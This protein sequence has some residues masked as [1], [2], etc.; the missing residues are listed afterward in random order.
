MLIS[1]LYSNIPA[2]QVVMNQASV[3][4]L[5]SSTHP[6]PH[7]RRLNPINRCR[8]YLQGNFF[9]CFGGFCFRI[10]EFRKIKRSIVFL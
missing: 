6:A 10:Q 3:P 5:P 4:W 2:I 7:R 9:G 8:L 1:N